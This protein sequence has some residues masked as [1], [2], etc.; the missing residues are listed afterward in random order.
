M[1]TEYGFTAVPRSQTKLLAGH[2]KDSPYIPIDDI[3]VPDT[4]VARAVNEYVK[5]ELTPETYNHSVRVYFYGT[6]IF[7]TQILIVRSSNC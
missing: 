3:A 6:I 1:A 7:F 5:Q 4:K 2:K